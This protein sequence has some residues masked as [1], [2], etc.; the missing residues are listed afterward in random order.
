MNKQ[1]HIVKKTPQRATIN[2][3]EAGVTLVEMGVVIVIIAALVVALTSGKS[4]MRASKERAV[5]QEIEAFQG[6]VVSFH[7]KYNDL[8]GD[9]SNAGIYFDD[10]SSGDGD[11]YIDG[12]NEPY[13][14]W[15]HLYMAKMIPDKLS[16]DGSIAEI[17]VNVPASRFTGAGYYFANNNQI[18]N[19]LGFGG[20][21]GSGDELDAAILSPE[22]ALGIDKK[23]DDGYPNDGRL[24]A[25]KESSGLNCAE[26]TGADDI[27]ELDVD[28]PSCFLR[29][30]LNT[31]A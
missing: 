17:G 14:A 3:P 7:E 30:R 12:P 21:Q 10:T 29:A 25:E 16:G 24:R 19:F 6:A 2:H 26:N 22:Q 13:L 1:N 8:P 20:Q 15:E 27:Y 28:A 9:I 5:A 31:E 23:V 4:I 11:E 18:G